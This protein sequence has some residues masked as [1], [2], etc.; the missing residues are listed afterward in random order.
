MSVLTLD[1]GTTT[2]WM[3]KR[4]GGVQVH[5]SWNLKGGRFEGGGMRYLRFSMHLE[6]LHKAS[7]L[8]LVYFEEVR[9]HN[10]TDAA[11]VYGG[12]MATLTA[13]CEREKIAY[14]G[15][16]VQTI[17]KFATGKGNADKKAVMAGVRKFGFEVAD[18]NEADAVALMLWATELPE[19]QAAL[20]MG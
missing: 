19:V 7:P 20:G 5:G 8:R 9:R 15:V 17:K 1:L 10:G 12:L 4:V 18:D 14:A 11:H 6:E 16:P 13:F 3:L 2:G